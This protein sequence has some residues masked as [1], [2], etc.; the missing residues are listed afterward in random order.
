MNISYVLKNRTGIYGFCAVWIVV[1][2]LYRRIS[3]PF[4]PVITNIVSLGNMAVDIFLFF[5]GVSLYLSAERNNYS[6]RGWKTYFTKRVC[7]ILVPYFI[8]AVPY[9]LW[10]II[11]ESGHRNFIGILARFVWNVSSASFWIKGVQTTW[12]VY[13]IAIFYLAFPILY[14]YIK[15]SNSA[16]KIAILLTAIYFFSVA[17]N[18]LPILKNSTIAWTRLPIFVIGI[19]A[20]KYYAKLDLSKLNIS[21]RKLLVSF[22]VIF[23]LVSGCFLSFHEIYDANTIQAVYIWLFYGPMTLSVIVCLMAVCKGD[24]LQA[25]LLKVLGSISLEIYLVHI[26]LL[27]PM[28][29]YGVLKYA[30]NW[31]YLLLP[32]CSIIIALGV[33][34]VEGV[35]I[36]QFWK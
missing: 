16:I 10:S 5:S 21:A 8:V 11:V 19:M 26:T 22:N 18:Y 34:W 32:I 29:F 23:L 12:Y 4:I 14:N 28:D 35:V 17:T 24:G 1:F 27:H 3:M 15:N 20:G 31:N 13:A 9:F 25:D 2:H 6:E 30:G 33:K 7:R 36:K